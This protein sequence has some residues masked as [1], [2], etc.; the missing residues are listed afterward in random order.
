M[1]VNPQLNSQI[2]R[3]QIQA[4][5]IEEIG[6]PGELKVEYEALA[7]MFVVISDDPIIDNDQKANTFW[8][9]VAS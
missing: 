7:R 3:R 1:S 2:W 6:Q 9:R 4:P 8:G 5:R